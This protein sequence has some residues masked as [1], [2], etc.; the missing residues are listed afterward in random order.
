MTHVSY[1][2]VRL[3]QTTRFYRDGSALAGTIVGGPAG[4]ETSVDVESDEPPE[5]VRRLV[6]MAEASCYALQ[7]LLQNMEV[8]SV[9]TLNGEA[10]PQAAPAV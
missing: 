10:L 5:R 3:Q 1:S 4:L 7:S 2:K 6:D 8:T 9:F